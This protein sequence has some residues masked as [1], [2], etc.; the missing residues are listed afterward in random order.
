MTILQS[1]LEENMIE[2]CCAIIIKDSK[3]LS[4]Q[5]GPNSGHPWKWEFPGGKTNLD[6]KPEQCIVREI[7]EELS[8]EIEVIYQLESIE[9]DYGNKQI[10]LV[11]FVAQIL[12]GEINMNEH[13]AIHWFTFDEWES[14]NWLEA[15]RK[16]IMKNK[17]RLK[18]VQSSCS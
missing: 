5:R 10:C 11:P 18:L 3:I 14:L 9:F 7:E 12:T 2:V 15:D 1:E 8:I 13:V 6:E 17:E 16:L 4:V